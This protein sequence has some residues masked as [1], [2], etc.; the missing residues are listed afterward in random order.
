MNENK[1]LIV[2]LGNIGAE[3]DGTHHNAGFL[4]ADE[5]ARSLGLTFSSERYGAVARGRLKNKQLVLLKP[6]TYM[7]LSGNAVRYW[8]QQEKVELKN[9]LIISDEL[10]LPF[11]TLRL[12]GQGSAGGHNG[13]K[14][15][16][17]LLGT[18]KY[19]RLRFGIGNDFRRGEQID[20]VLSRFS[21]EEM[22]EMPTLLERAAETA[23]SFVL[24]G[25]ERTMN[26]YNTRGNKKKETNDEQHHED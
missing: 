23:K 14:N 4:V 12:K 7:N 3:Y 15:I 22:K 5:I 18:N 9:L 26:T 10:A 24:A 25:L 1:Y 19:A 17:E 13:L 2:G 11:G 6:N 21:D 20:F 16:E 8:L